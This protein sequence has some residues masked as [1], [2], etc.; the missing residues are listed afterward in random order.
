M[1]GRL[2]FRIAFGVS[3]LLV[4]GL[5]SAQGV[6]YVVLW[7]DTEDY[8]DPIADDAALRIANDLTGL[9]VRATFKVVGEKGRVLERRGRMDVIQGLGKHA[10]GYHSD[11]HSISLRRRWPWSVWDCLKERRISN[12]DSAR[13]SKTLR[14]FSA[15]LQFATD[16]PGLL[17]LRSRTWLYAEWECMSIWMRDRRSD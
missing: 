14:V 7:F 6:T 17:G 5:A 15:L 12:G 4:A 2:R 13:V 1:R 9:G 8:V 10:I 3:L 16:N 11:W